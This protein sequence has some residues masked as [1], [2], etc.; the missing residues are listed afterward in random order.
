ML[1][2][3]HGR[4]INYLR[5]AVTDRCNLRCSYCMPGHGLAWLSRSEL[6]SYAE[7]LRLCSVLIGLG[8]NKV[9][10]TGG[11]PF[12]RKDLMKFLS[13]LSR[14]DGLQE[15]TLT[16]NGVATAPHVPE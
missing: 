1:L 11:E 9:R 4:I 15:I 5:L 12:V 3:N 7:M 2:D 6:L 10:I 16:T 13:A 14:L 8:I